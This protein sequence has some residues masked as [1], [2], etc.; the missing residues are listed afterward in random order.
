MPWRLVASLLALRTRRARHPPARRRLHPR[1][2]LRSRPRQ[3]R[4]LEGDRGQRAHPLGDLLHAREPR[5]DGAAVPELFAPYRVRPRRPLPA[6]AA[7]RA[8]L[9]RPVGRERG[10]GRRV[11]AGPGQPRL[12]R[13]RLP[14]APDGRR[15]GRG[16]GPRRARRRLLH[17]HH[18][19]PGAR[20]RDLPPPRRR[21]H[22]PARVPRRD[23]LLG[24]PGPDPRLPRRHRRD[25]QRDRHRRRR[26]QGDLLLR[27]RR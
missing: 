6:A 3:R 25:R 21:L 24:V 15:A 27:A 5:R 1:R 14:R 7:R 17:A 12:L 23:S 18:Q 8:A 11:D 4:R 16:L 26:R 20:Q 2:R 19:R 22:R 10:D 9:G 13:A